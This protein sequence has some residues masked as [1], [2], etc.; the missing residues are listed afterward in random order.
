MRGQPELIAVTIFL[1]CLLERWS[2]VVK[3]GD[4][5]RSFNTWQDV[6]KDVMRNLE[7]LLNTEQP[8]RLAGRPLPA[9]VQRSVLCYGI[10]AY[11]GKVQSSFRVDDVAWSI[12]ERIVAFETRIEAA[13]LTVVASEQDEQNR[14][15][16][17]RFTIHGFLRADPL[18]LEF[19]V[20]SELDMESGTARITG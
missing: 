11:S 6:R 12:R 15:N 2:S 9:A 7:W 20:Q 10:P 14:F 3:G 4:A 13:S 18:P 5:A 16:C 8:S 1:P 17:M 19:L